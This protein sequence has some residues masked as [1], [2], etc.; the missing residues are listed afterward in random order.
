MNKDLSKYVKPGYIHTRTEMY[1][2]L[3]RLKGVPFDTTAHAIVEALPAGTNVHEAMV[4]V[5]SSLLVRRVHDPRKRGGR[6]AEHAGSEQAV[7]T[8]DAFI[9]MDSEEDAATFL[10]TTT[11]VQLGETTIEIQQTEMLEL[12][13]T[14]GCC[15]V[16]LR[17][18]D[19]RLKNVLRLQQLPHAVQRQHLEELF[20][21]TSVVSVVNLCG[22]QR[23]K[24]CVRLFQD[25]HLESSGP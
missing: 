7:P 13:R 11:S 16:F 6:A 10:Q 22:G 23:M 1:Q 25:L 21:G 4:I 2:G 19:A 8:Q 15:S 24:V 18:E 17:H 3:L 5:P 12:I 14:I 9:V 20:Q